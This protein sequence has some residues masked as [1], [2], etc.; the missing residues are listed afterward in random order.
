MDPLE[1]L[2]EDNHLLVIN[3]P[4]GIATMGAEAG[5]TIHSLAAD[6]LKKTYAKPGKAFVGVVSRLDSMTSG[7]LVLAR[8]SKAASR[9][10]S[11]FAQRS[12]EGTDKIYLAA[13]EG[14]LSEFEGEFEDHVRKDDAAHRMRIVGGTVDQAKEARLRYCRLLSGETNSVV[15][16]RLISGRKHQIRLQ[17]A[18]RGHP[19]LG[20]RKYGATT[21]FTAGI[22]LHSWRLRI[23]HPTKR[24]PMWFRADP[25]PTWKPLLKHLALDQRLERMVDRSLQ[26]DAG[27]GE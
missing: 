20:D 1:V 2:Y 6:Y 4:V 5:P 17:F 8:T 18:D 23:M 19:V 24:T 21:R 22:A 11:Q 25:P 7:V 13:I 3:K 12:G 9:L 10:S 16:V 26:I 27:D 14:S 15:A